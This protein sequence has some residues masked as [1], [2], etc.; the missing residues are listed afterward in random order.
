[1]ALLAVKR[2]AVGNGPFAPVAAHVQDL[3]GAGHN[4]PRSPCAGQ[5]HLADRRGLVGQGVQPPVLFGPSQPATLEEPKDVGQPTVP[6]NRRDK[7]RIVVAPALQ[8]HIGKVAAPIAGGQDG[9]PAF[10]VA[11]NHGDSRA[12]LGC[13]DAGDKARGPAAAHGNVAARRYVD[14]GGSGQRGGLNLGP[15]WPL[16]SF[17]CVARHVHWPVLYLRAS[18]GAPE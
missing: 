12:L 17:C 7:L 4:D 3:T 8:P 14:V 9:P 13:G 2:V 16:L 15:R 11:L 6:G 18:L 10:Q 1:M 5:K